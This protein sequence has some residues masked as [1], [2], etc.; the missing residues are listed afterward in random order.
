MYNLCNNNTNNKLHLCMAPKSTANA[1]GNWCLGF[2]RL[3]CSQSSMESRNV[4]QWLSPELLYDMT[5][6]YDII[7]GTKTHLLHTL[8]SPVVFHVAA[9]SVLSWL[10][11]HQI[12]S[13]YIGSDM[14]KIA[15]HT[16]EWSECDQLVLGWV[17][18]YGQVNHLGS[19]HRSIYINT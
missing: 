17:T 1:V 7:H 14:R 6:I 12:S 10:W 9:L 15:A 18:L 16:N 19:K 13:S 11:S 8:N 3:K 2:S 4:D 5:L